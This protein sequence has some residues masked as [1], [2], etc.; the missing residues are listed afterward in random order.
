MTLVYPRRSER[1]TLRRKLDLVFRDQHGQ[2]STVSGLTFAV[3]CHGCGL[4]ARPAAPLGSEVYVMSSLEGMGAW[5]HLVWEGNT[6]RDGRQPVGIEFMT[7]RNY[8][9]QRM[10][11]RSWLPYAVTRDSLMTP[12][13][14]A[15]A[16]LSPS[17]VRRAYPGEPCRCCGSGENVA[18]LASHPEPLCKVCRSWIV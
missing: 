9:G 5:G 16:P 6:L 3:S 12:A 8:W 11:P 1:I 4:Y 14:E 2:V 18:V 17:S 13:R 15:G 10:I 7:P